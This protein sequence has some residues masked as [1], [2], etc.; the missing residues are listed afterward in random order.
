[1]KARSQAEAQARGELANALAHGAGD[2]EK[3]ARKKLAALGIA[4][5]TRRQAAEATDEGAEEQR[6]TPPKGRTR[7]P[8]ETT[9]ASPEREAARRRP[10]ERLQLG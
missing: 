4:A 7:R 9:Q 6:T 3:A 1:M 2:R 5:E 10:G 8:Q